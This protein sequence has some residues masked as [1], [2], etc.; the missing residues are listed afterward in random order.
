MSDNEDPN[1]SYEKVNKGDAIQ[2]GGHEQIAQDVRERTRNQSVLKMM[3]MKVGFAI[4]FK[5]KVGQSTRVRILFKTFLHT[6]PKYA[7]ESIQS[8][9]VDYTLNGFSLSVTRK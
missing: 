2:N 6:V 4:N 5:R 9:L 7:R 1:K 8:T 3:K